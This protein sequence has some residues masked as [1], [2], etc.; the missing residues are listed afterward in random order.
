M[1][2]AEHSLQRGME[3]PYDGKQAADWAH[4]AAQGVLADLLDRRGIKWQFEECDEETKVEITKS[5]AE[6]IRLAGSGIESLQPKGVLY[7]SVVYDPP[8]LMQKGQQLICYGDVYIVRDT[9][10]SFVQSGKVVRRKE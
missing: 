2:D 5:M 1:S 10:G 6:I 7:E 9:I 3:F 4:A 8:V